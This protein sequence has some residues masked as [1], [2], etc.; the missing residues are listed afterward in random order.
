MYCQENNYGLH[1]IWYHIFVVE[2]IDALLLFGLTLRPTLFHL[3]PNALLLGHLV[4]F[5]CMLGF[6][7]RFS[8]SWSHKSNQNQQKL[9]ISFF[10]FFKSVVPQLFHLLGIHYFAV[11][12]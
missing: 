12:Y 6:T 8:I 4:F 7:Y 9:E 1:R 5:N 2:E 10:S 11:T 3:L